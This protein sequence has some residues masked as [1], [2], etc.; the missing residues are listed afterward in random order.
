MTTDYL[1]TSKDIEAHYSDYRYSVPTASL[2]SS[3]LLRTDN[4]GR[5]PTLELITE[6]ISQRL[7][8]GFQICTPA[9]AVGALD[10]VNIATSKTTIDVLAEMHKGDPTAV[11]LSLSNQIHRISFERRSQTVVVKILRR[12]QTWAHDPY[13]YGA[14]VW[15]QGAECFAY[16]K[17][18]FP[19][20]SMIDPADWE[21]LDRLVA[22]AEKPDLRPGLRYWRTRLVLLPAASVPNR[23]SL[24]AAT[25]A[26]QDGEVT[27]DDIQFQGFLTWMSLIEALRWVPPGGEREHTDVQTCVISFFFRF[28]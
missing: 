25:P 11:Y 23:D 24:V 9:D 7:S 15:P 20:P 27:D 17:L 14:L 21:H 1:P 28:C 8:H 13:A 3:F 26:L 19:F 5:S 4:P 22:G 2:T 16:E 6:L 10:E 18:A 12:R